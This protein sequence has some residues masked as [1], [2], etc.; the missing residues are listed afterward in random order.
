M[1][2]DHMPEAT[3]LTGEIIGENTIGK[4]A[5]GDSP[6]DMSKIDIVPLQPREGEIS[7]EMAYQLMERAR[8]VKSPL[9]PDGNAM[10]RTLAKMK[11]PPLPPVVRNWEQ[12]SQ[13][14]YFEMRAA[15]K[16]GEN[17]MTMRLP[18]RADS[19]MFTLKNRLHLVPG[20]RSSPIGPI[21]KDH[22]ILNAAN[23][24]YA[25]IAVRAHELFKY[26]VNQLGDR[27]SW[28]PE[29]AKFE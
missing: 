25:T 3:P 24:P 20:D 4:N 1:T 14:A 29:D 2:G 17:P 18:V 6:I 28:L 5:I 16:R 7:H 19:S 26:A 8:Q 10:F 12:L 9:D 27:P 22:W 15:H 11:K 23:K 13:I 21:L